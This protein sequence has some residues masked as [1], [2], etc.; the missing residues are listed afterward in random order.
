MT[1]V[2]K[3]FA[4]AAVCGAAIFAFSQSSQAATWSI[5]GGGA[6]TD[7][8]GY[9]TLPGQDNVINFAPSHIVDPSPTAANT[10]QGANLLPGTFSGGSYNVAW[11]YMGSESDNT[12]T[13]TAPGVSA[14]PEDNRNNNCCQGSL[15]LGPAAMG[16][17]TG[18]TSTSAIPFS[19]NDASNG[20]TV[21]NGSNSAAGSGFANFT[22]SYASL[23]GGNLVIGSSGTP[24]D[25]IIIGFNDNGFNDDNHDDFIVAAQILDAGRETNF[26]PIPAALPLFGSVLGGGF[27]FRR[28]RN[29]RKAKA[30]TA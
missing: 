14:F 10:I 12:I 29:R 6:L 11:F 2:A 21:T 13:F 9:G 3:R 22:L 8:P 19:F 24:T 27:L 4:L 17:A 5:S 18:L 28:L 25:W 20:H 23:I 1:S 16:S 26:T 30:K 15:P 7:F